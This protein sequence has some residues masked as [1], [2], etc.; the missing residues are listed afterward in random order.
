MIRKATYEDYVRLVRSIQNKK[1]VK[2]YINKDLLR[3]DIENSSCYI[4]IENNK[5]VAMISL[6]YDNNYQ[7]YYLKRLIIPNK[8]NHGKSIAK[9]MI[10]YFQTNFDFPINIT[11]WED[12]APMIGIVE[13]LGFQFQYK[14][15][16]NY[17]LYTYVK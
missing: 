7:S 15:L 5:I 10:S 16:E 2:S 13:K 1:E 12:N 3:K 9:E 6:V 14:F 4:K 8:K 11:P 17:M